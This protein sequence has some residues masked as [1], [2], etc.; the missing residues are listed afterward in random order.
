MDWQIIFVASAFISMLGGMWKIARDFRI[1]LAETSKQLRE[2]SDKTTRL[3]FKRFD[4]HKEAMD[5]KTIYQTEINDKKY[6]QSNICTLARTNYDKLFE[7]INSKLDMLL[8]ERRH[9]KNN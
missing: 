8:E 6:A 4:D 5:K 2:D 7:S 1:D 3:L 9:A